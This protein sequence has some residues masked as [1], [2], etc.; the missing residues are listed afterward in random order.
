MC[1]YLI[2][3]LL[4][5][6]LTD[7][8]RV[9]HLCGIW[10]PLLQDSNEVLREH[11]SLL[12]PIGVA[13]PCGVWDPLFRGNSMGSMLHFSRRLSTPISSFCLAFLVRSK[14]IEATLSGPSC[15]SKRAIYLYVWPEIH[16]SSR[17]HETNLYGI[18]ECYDGL[19][20]LTPSIQLRLHTLC[21]V[22]DP[23]LS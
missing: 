15:L 4:S 19:I 16:I 13:H 1:S 7:P 22:W 20:R 10:G 14:S 12:S 3:V 5:G 17:Q 8:I 18:Q 23:F 21:M 11:Q 2:Y 6:I 9:T